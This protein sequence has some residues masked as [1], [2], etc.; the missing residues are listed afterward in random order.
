MKNKIIKSYK[1]ILVYDKLYEGYVMKNVWICECEK[2][3]QF[4]YINEDDKSDEK[5]KLVECPIC[6]NKK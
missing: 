4:A 5:I 2:D 3:H 1:G 6:K